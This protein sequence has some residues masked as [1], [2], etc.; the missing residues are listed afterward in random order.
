MFGGI[1]P[2]QIEIVIQE[3]CMLYDLEL[4]N[5]NNELEQERKKNEQQDIRMEK[6]A[7]YVRQVLETLRSQIQ[8]HFPGKVFREW[9]LGKRE[10]DPANPNVFGS[11]DGVLTESERAAVKELRFH[12]STQS[13]PLPPAEGLDLTG[14]EYFPNLT[15]LKA[16]FRT[17]MCP[18]E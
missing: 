7:E 14:I 1:A 2:K 3:I 10:G 8:E 12:Y 18:Q 9:L 4:Y 16:L 6:V 11:D 13:G 5:K 17:P 15:M